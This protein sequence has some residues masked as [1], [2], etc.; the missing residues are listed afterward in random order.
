MQIPRNDFECKFQGTLF[1][2]EKLI[3]FWWESGWLSASRK[4][5]TTFWNLSSTTHV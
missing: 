1:K 5:L 2:G 3:R 4:H